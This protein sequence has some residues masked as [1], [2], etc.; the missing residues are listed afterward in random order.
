MVSQCIKPEHHLKS[1]A[2]EYKRTSCSSSANEIVPSIRS[3]PITTIVVYFD[4]EWRWDEDFALNWTRIKL[5]HWSSKGNEIDST[6]TDHRHRRLV[7][8]RMRMSFWPWVKL[9]AWTASTRMQTYSLVVSGKRDRYMDWSKITA[10]RS[11]PLQCISVEHDILNATRTTASRSSTGMQTYAL[12]TE[13]GPS[14][15]SK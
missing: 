5:T 12:A 4:I 10:R 3:V 2:Q 15:Q 11:S 9:T 13:T 8:Q 6:N 7:W 14:F 1:Q